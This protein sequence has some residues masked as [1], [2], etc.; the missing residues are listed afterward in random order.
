MEDGADIFF[1]FGFALEESVTGGGAD[2]HELHMVVAGKLDF[3]TER[4][5]QGSIAGAADEER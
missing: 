3:C 5:W 4:L 1:K 2:S